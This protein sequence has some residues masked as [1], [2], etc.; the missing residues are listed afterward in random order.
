M[1]GGDTDYLRPPCVWLAHGVV[2]IWAFAFDCLGWQEM[3][4]MDEQ[5]VP[6]QLTLVLQR[7]FEVEGGSVS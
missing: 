5:S 1:R 3:L 6:V 7:F 4:W 2:L